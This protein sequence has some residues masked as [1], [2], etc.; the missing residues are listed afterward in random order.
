[1]LLYAGTTSK[2]KFN[3]YISKN[4]VKKFK[5]WSKSAGNLIISKFKNN[6]GTSETLRNKTIMNFRTKR[7][8]S[9][10]M[11]NYLRPISYE[12][13]GNYLA[14]LIDSSG[15]INKKKQLIIVFREID[16]SL[17]YY[18]KKRIGYGSVKKIKDKNIILLVISKEKGIKKVITWINGRLN[19]KIKYNQ[20]VR[21][22][23]NSPDFLEFKKQINFRKNLNNNL[24]NHW[25][26]GFSDSLGNFYVNYTNPLNSSLQFKINWNDISVLLLIKEFIGGSIVYNRS[27]NIYTY[28]VDNS[29]L[30]IENVIHYFDQYH[31]LS[32]NYISFFKW[33][34]SFLKLYGKYYK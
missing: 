3:Y 27:I 22:L 29:I 15:D 7:W 33:R 26:A 23:L 31:L 12:E 14:G 18:I 32:K 6:N 28:K 16:F 11:P 25:L 21:N 19:S 13:F 9:V 10:H 17:A 1:M 30:M 34:K 2:N 5:Q 4:K 20:I 24:N 8:V